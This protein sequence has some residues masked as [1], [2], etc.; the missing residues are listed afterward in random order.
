MSVGCVFIESPLA[1]RTLNII[2]VIGRWRRRRKFATLFECLI[3][4]FC[5]S[6]GGDEFLVFSS[7][8]RWFLWWFWPGFKRLD[9]G[10]ISPLSSLPAG[11]KR[12]PLFS[13]SFL[14][15]GSMF[16]LL[17]I[18]KGSIIFS[19]LQKRTKLKIESCLNTLKKPSG[20]KL[21]LSLI[22]LSFKVRAHPGTPIHTH[23]HTYLSGNYGE[24][25]SYDFV[26]N[27][28]KF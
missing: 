3:K 22:R 20:K 21:H 27:H 15:N 12:L 1:I 16:F 9:G 7:P 26:R 18:K 28:L 19:F 6:Y 8:I 25:L 23:T 13:G 14:A 2:R 11:I 5:C 10:N 4:A 24:I 17:K